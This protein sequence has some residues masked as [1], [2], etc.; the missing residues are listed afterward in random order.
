MCRLFCPCWKGWIVTC[1]GRFL[2]WYQAYCRMNYGQ[3][4]TCGPGSFRINRYITLGFRKNSWGLL[5]ALE[6]L[7]LIVL[8]ELLRGG[9]QSVRRKF[10]ALYA[11]PRME[12]TYQSSW[13]YLILSPGLSLI[14]LRC[15]FHA[16][17]LYLRSAISV[18]ICSFLLL[19]GWPFPVPFTLLSSLRCG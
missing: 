17:L 11:Q 15:P 7:P 10:V 9:L 19:G 3:L 6:G 5:S 1:I 13:K 16:C 4:S 8:S 12:V 18:M 2:V 14:Q